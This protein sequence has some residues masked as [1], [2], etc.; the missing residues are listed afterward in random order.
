M[1]APEQPP[2]DLRLTE[3][4]LTKFAFA[5]MEWMGSTTSLVVHT[6]VF[7]AAFVVVLLGASW[8][9]VLLIVT[10]AVSLEA[11]YM[12][13]LIQMGVN[14]NTKSLRVVE[15]DVDEIQKDVD[16]I[17]KDVDGI[18]KDSNED[19]ARDT[20]QYKALEKIQEQLIAIGLELQKIKSDEKKL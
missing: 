10:T 17:Q 5:A 19:E 8:T 12:N 15:E 4:K 2:E 20:Q 18:E 14:Q 16:E 9:A 7:I 11:I 13:I 3:T 6:I 1:N